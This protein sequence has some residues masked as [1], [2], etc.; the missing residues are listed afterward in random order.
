M[1]PQI[2]VFSCTVLYIPIWMDFDESSCFTMC[3]YVC[4]CVSVASFLLQQCRD[5]DVPADGLSV[6]AAGEQVAQLVLIVP[7]CTTHHTP[8]SH[9]VAAWKSGQ[10]H[11]VHVKQSD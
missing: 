1:R 8:V 10:P 2:T 9:S 7:R 3:Y 5:V 11:S 6:E 4:L